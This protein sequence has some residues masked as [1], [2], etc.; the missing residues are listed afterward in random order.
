VRGEQR[1]HCPRRS[2]AHVAA[3]QHQMGV[4]IAARLQQRRMT[5]IVD[6]EVL[7]RMFR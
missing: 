3:A 6:A 1:R 7:M 4:R 5:E 2:W